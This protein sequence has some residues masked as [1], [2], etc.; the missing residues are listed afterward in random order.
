[1][2]VTECVH[3]VTFRPQAKPLDYEQVKTY[4]AAKIIVS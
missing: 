3:F 4:L 2:K 1:M